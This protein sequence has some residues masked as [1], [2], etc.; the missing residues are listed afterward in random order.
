M[1]QGRP[2]SRIP[3]IDS[4]HCPEQNRRVRDSARHRS[5]CI[6]AVSNWNDAAAT[7]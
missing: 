2:C 1:A 6:L 3:F 5:R 7:Q 4:G